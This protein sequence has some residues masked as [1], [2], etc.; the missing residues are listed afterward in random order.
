MV[1]QKEINVI[2]KNKVVI[3]RQRRQCYITNDWQEIQNVNLFRNKDV[4][5]HST[6]INNILHYSY[7]IY[8]YMYIF[9]SAILFYVKICQLK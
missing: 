6:A 4:A 2:L 7:F 5:G 9:Y 1:C 8:I 3:M